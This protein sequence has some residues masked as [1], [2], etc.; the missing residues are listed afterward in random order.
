MK[1]SKETLSNYLTSQFEKNILSKKKVRTI[2]DYIVNEGN[3]PVIEVM[4]ALTLRK[5]IED[6]SDRMLYW[7]TKCVDGDVV[8]KYFSQKEIKEYE[9]TKYKKETVKFPIKWDMIEIV[10]GTQWVGRISV[11]ELMKL[12]N[13]QL[14]NYNERTQRTLKHVANQ[15]FQYY[16]IFLN[17]KAVSEIAESF[18]ENQYIPN[19]ITLNLP[20]D[21][22]FTYKDGKLTISETDRF[23]ILDGYHRYIAMSNLYN[24]NNSFDYPMELRVV[25]F[26]EETARQFIWQEDQK[27]KMRKMDSESLNQNSPANQVVNLINQILVCI[28][29]RLG[30]H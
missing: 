27:T 25:C 21:A 15:D 9:T 2:A 29:N 11:K 6:Y 13:A 26:S 16:Q 24:R 12:R 23:D 20:Q 14:I 18:Y 8:N 1:G 19:T 30:L 7:F 10:E 22:E 17:R 4:D 28:K 3:L 5:N